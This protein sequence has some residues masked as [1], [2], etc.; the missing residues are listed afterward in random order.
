MLHC[1]SRQLGVFGGLDRFGFVLD[2]LKISHTQGMTNRY[3]FSSL[4]WSMDQR[5]CRL[6]RER[7][8]QRERERERGRERERELSFASVYSLLLF[9]AQAGSSELLPLRRSVS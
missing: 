5:R 6:A 9:L 8:R 7:E 1:M 4:F 2:Y 3:C